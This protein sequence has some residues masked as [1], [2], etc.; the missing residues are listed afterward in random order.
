MPVEAC[1]FY[2]E[3]TDGKT[4]LRPNPGDRWVCCSFGSV[5]CLP[6]QEARECCG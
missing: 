6:I 4:L 1:E 5:P 2:Y 3:C